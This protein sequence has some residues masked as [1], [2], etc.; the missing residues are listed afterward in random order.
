MGAGLTLLKQIGADAA[1][2]GINTG[3][4]MIL[5]GYNDR[6]QL[7]QQEKLQNLQ[8]AGNKQ[9]L[10][11]Q[12]QKELE[13]WNATNYSAQKEQMK[14]AG[15]NPALLYGMSG[16]GGT[17]I[18]GG[19][20]GVSGGQAP[21]G[22][23]E[24]QEL[25]GM[26]L[27]RRQLELQAELQ[28]AQ[29]DN[30]NADTKKKNVE[31]GKTAGVDTDEAKQR[32]SLMAQQEDNA[33]WQYE[34]LRLDKAMKELDLRMKDETL[35]DA[36]SGF[37]AVSKY[38]IAEMEEKMADAK[39][40]TETVNDRIATVK[41]ELAAKIM[42]SILMKSNVSV[43]EQQIEKMRADVANAIRGLDIEQQKINLQSVMNDWQK[44]FPGLGQSAG[45]LMNDAVESV[46]KLIGIKRVKHY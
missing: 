29:I 18:G 11:Y 21:S 45:R 1:S 34:L 38:Q 8:I 10:D 26:G 39:V 31:A 16:G 28:K 14:K 9:M 27:Q 6:R 44:Q 5:G 33:R 3:M 43:N 30:I 15:I 17:T 12:M 2:T 35:D 20:G 25:L 4:G 40:A 42:Q 41:A 46:F 36:I 37:I 13:M 7:R 19:S 22:G 32:I 24:V 23:R